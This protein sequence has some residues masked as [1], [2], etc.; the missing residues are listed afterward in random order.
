[1]YF[2]FVFLFFSFQLFLS[3]FS[4]GQWNI[5]PTNFFK[6]CRSHKSNNLTALSS[7]VVTL[8]VPVSNRSSSNSSTISGT[9]YIGRSI[10]CNLTPELSGFRL[11]I[12]IQSW[13]LS[14]KNQ[15]LNDWFGERA[16]GTELLLY[17][18]KNSNNGC[19]GFFFFDKFS[20]V[21]RAKYD[22]VQRDR[23]RRVS[24][25]THYS[26][27]RQPHTERLGERL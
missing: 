26:T 12:E 3:W 14:M 2:F 15:T 24:L 23:Q 6:S 17:S 1:M 8:V 5:S 9:S 4:R 22:E 11:I 18:R 13:S 16:T 7:I 27:G 21:T 19:H 25:C 20:L 10:W